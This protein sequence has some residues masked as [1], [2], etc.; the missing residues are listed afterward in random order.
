VRYEGYVF[1]SG[2]RFNLLQRYL[3]LGC[4]KSINVPYVKNILYKLS[5]IAHNNNF[6][7]EEFILFGTWAIFETVVVSFAGIGSLHPSVG[8]L[9]PVTSYRS[10]VVVPNPNGM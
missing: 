10:I 1:E 5:K 4:R 9:F 2:A 6:K 8:L 3:A 7:K